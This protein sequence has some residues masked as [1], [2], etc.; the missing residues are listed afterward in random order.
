MPLRM[1]KLSLICLVISFILF[2]VGYYIEYTYPNFGMGETFL[3]ITMFAFMGRI[4]LYLLIIVL[5]CYILESI[6]PTHEKQR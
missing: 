2:E 4:L 6:K 3:I 1:K 5:W